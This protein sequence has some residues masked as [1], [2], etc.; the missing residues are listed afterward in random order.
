MRS[1]LYEVGSARQ[2]AEVLRAEGREA[3]RRGYVTS[4]EV[5][6]ELA[7]WLDPPR[8]ETESANGK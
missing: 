1:F 7:D 6:F 5:D 3:A 4:A 2:R 8:R